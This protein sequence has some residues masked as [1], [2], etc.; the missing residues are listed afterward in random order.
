MLGASVGASVEDSLLGASVGASVDGS[1]LGASVGASVDGSSLGAS[2]GASVDGSSLGASVDGSSL[3]FSVGASVGGSSGSSLPSA[4]TVLTITA[5]V[6]ERLPTN[7][8]SMYPSVA[9]ASISPTAYV[10]L[11]FDTLTLSP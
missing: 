3:G 10:A 9:T 8:I 1:S 2:V 4:L 6:L 11:P 7:S 5:H